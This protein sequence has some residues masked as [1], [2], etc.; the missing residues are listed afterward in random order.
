MRHI[1]LALVAVALAFGGPQQKAGT[2]PPSPEIRGVVLEPGTNQPVVEAEVTLSV[3]GPGPIRINGGWQRDD[4][5]KATTDH[6]GAFTLLLEKPGAYRVEAKRPGYVPSEAS[7]ASDYAELTLTA[8]KPTAEVKLF[9]TRPGQLTGSVVD[10][11]TS[12][13]I[14]NLRL[15]AARKMIVFGFL[16]AGGTSATTDAE[17]RFA[18]T[19]LQPGE[20]AVVVGP[21]T[22]PDKRVLTKFTAQDVKTVES[23]YEQTYWPGGH[24][25]EAVLPMTVASG[26]TVDVGQLQV[27][28]VP[29]YRVHVRIPV[30]NCA[31]GDT[32][33]VTEAAVTQTSIG[34]RPLAQVPCGKDVLVTGFSPGDYRLILGIDGRTSETRGTAS[35]PFSISDENIEIAAPLTPGVAL[36]G[37]VVAAEGAKPPDFAKVRISLRAVDGFGS[38]VMRDA[39]RARLRR[40]VSDRGPAAPR[41]HG[42]RIRAGAG[43]L[44]EGDS[45]QRHSVEWRHH[46][47]RPGGTSAHVDDCRGR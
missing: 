18:A 38:M 25:P 47:A 11:E 3:Q 2:P 33:R 39:H 40:E 22:E 21:Q 15:S 14:A 45:L 41:S 17:G 44:R 9:L 10:E 28:K 23:D 30:S 7:G 12:K 42:I 19:G 6:S 46:T 4:A 16:P 32:M 43:Q 1:G 8:E 36:E 26:A 5:R 34:I 37:A 24:G 13:P 35:V 31:D 27:R 20:Y 29:Y